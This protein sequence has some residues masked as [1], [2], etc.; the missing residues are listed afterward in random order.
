MRLLVDR[1]GKW[2]FVSCYSTEWIKMLYCIHFSSINY[3]FFYFIGRIRTTPEYHEVDNETSVLSLNLFPAS[4]IQYPGDDRWDGLNM[5]RIMQ[6]IIVRQLFLVVCWSLIISIVYTCTEFS[7]SEFTFALRQLGIVPYII[8]ICWTKS[9][10]LG[11]GYIWLSQLISRLEKVQNILHYMSVHY[12][13]WT[14]HITY[15][16]KVENCQ[17]PA[18]ITKDLSILIHSRDTKI[19]T[20]RYEHNNFLPENTP[21]FKQYCK[22]I[23]C[24]VSSAEPLGVYLEGANLWML[25]VWVGF[26]SCSC[27]EPQNQV[28]QVSVVPCLTCPCRCV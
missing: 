19:S 1:Y 21:I 18:C 20:S 14:Y 2:S 16:F 26:T 9:L 17:Q 23:S 10:L 24:C 6:T 28:V 27:G 12:V 25:T 22:H 4:Y 3:I 15:L 13:I 8:P 5:T 7:V 11:T